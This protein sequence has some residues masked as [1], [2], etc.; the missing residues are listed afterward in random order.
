MPGVPGAV[1]VWS[2]RDQWAPG[3]SATSRAPPARRVT[4]GP[5]NGAAEGR[6][7]LFVDPPSV[8]FSVSSYLD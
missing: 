4:G 5:P 7:S 1:G 6:A 3:E 8:W 2:R